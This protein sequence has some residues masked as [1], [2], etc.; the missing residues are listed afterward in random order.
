MKQTFKLFALTVMSLVVAI[1]SYAQVTTS[2]MSGK[3]AESSGSPVVGAAVVAIHTPSGT[4]YYSITDNAGNYRIQ[5]MR[6]GGPYSIEVTLLGFGTNKFEGGNL[7][8]GENFVHNVVLSEEAI[9][10]NEVVVSAGVV[11]PILNSDKN[12][13]SLNISERQIAALPSIS[14]S[15]TDF[16]RMT[17]QSNGT[18]FAGRDG[19]MN[20]ISIDGAA[21]NNNFGLSSNAMPGGSAQPISL[22]AI[23]QVS[24]N[25]APFDIRQS[26]FTG[27]S[28]N[29]VT[30]SGDNT[31]RASVYTYLRPKSFTGEKVGDAIVTN[32]K[33]KQA[34]TYGARVGGPIIKDKL[35]FFVSGEYEKETS[36]SGAWEPSTDGKSNVEQKI[37]RTTVADLKTMSDFLMKTYNYDAGSYQNFR[38]FESSNYKILAR[39]DW[40][41]SRNHKFTVRYNQ[42]N[43]T[44]DNLTNANSAPN[45]RGDSRSSAQS[46]A[47]GNSWYGF[48][49]SVK[50]ITGELNSTF[51]SKVS[52]KLLISYTAIKDTR[53]SPS[54]EFPFVDIYNG[55]KQYMSF[56]YELFSYNN[57]VKNNTLSISDNVSIN[58]NKHTL[59]AGISY[60]YMYF[61]NAY[62]REA[63]SYYRYDSM[64]D[65]MSDRTPN[66]FAVT[67]GF[68]GAAAPGVELG[69]GQAALYVQDEWQVN[70]K[71]K[72]TY[73]IRAEL[74]IYHNKVEGPSQY[75]HKYYEEG[76]KDAQYENVAWDGKFGDYTMDLG[77][78]PKSKLQVSPRIGFNWDVLGDRS[79]QVRGGTGLFTGLL[80]FVWFTNQPNGSGRIQSP[81][82]IITDQKQIE[83]LRKNGKLF[84]PN[85]RE[86]ISSNPAVFTQTPGVLPNGSSVAEVDK[87]FKMPQVW[88]SNIA[89]DFELPWN[90]VFTLEYLYSKDVNAVMQKDVNLKEADKTLVG[91]DN[92][93]YWTSKNNNSDIRNAMLLTNTSKGYQNSITAQLTKNF[94]KGL[95]GMVAYTYTSAKDISSNPGSTAASAWSSNTVISSLN[96][97]ELS[98]SNFAVPHR[99]VGNISY[100]IEYAKHLAS[101]FSLYYSGA[102][103][104]RSTFAYSNDMNYDGNASDLMYIPASKDEVKFID[105]LSSKGEVLMTA[106]EQADVFWNYVN[107]DKYLKENKGKY[108]ERFGYV[109]PWYNR[110]DFKFLQD[111]YTNFGTDRRYT[112]QVSLDI[113]NVGNLLCKDWGVY[114]TMG[115][116]N[117]DRIRPLTQV[118]KYGPDKNNPKK[119]IPSSGVGSDGSNTYVLNGSSAEGFRNN[120]TWKNNVSVGST[121]GM[122]LGFR[123]IF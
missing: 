107:E 15:I 10:L 25:I 40:N 48:E 91:A 57:E 29:A 8:L 58:L 123:L 93:P 111:I 83:T 60:D 73:G 90:L 116:K 106:A 94:T 122:L 17:P 79:I 50:S 1:A 72:L 34:Q 36:P 98:Y 13:T 42:M 35:F 62:M 37:S 5:N 51:G 56:G 44:S 120:N 99:V 77:K 6:I 68:N 69:F 11:N 109:E 30:K 66:A 23:D 32:A 4:Q 103:Q 22:D 20:T 2:S 61:K 70:K 76:V 59:T 100:R 64:D 119:I 47:F 45:P 18:S 3:V 39:V 49:N 43:N 105:M 89:V 110:W 63:T 52:N 27:A 102:P 19:R 67:Y 112:L 114:Q 12:G 74:P 75:S 108:A 54:E 92:R 95:S 101:T 117:Y 21:F 31:Y 55:G 7:R 118:K 16:T 88:R 33:E 53:T 86:M 38:N 46:V 80:P 78:W 14:R 24:V 41:I 65:F 121:W 82:I 26:Q 9:A 87:D 84:N 71:L 85:F 115:T 113:L 81:E 96:N 97:P 104:G 28:I